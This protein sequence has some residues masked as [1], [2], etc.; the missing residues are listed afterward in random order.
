MPSMP[1]KEHKMLKHRL[2]KA[3]ENIQNIPD[4]PMLESVDLAFNMKF[5]DPDEDQQIDHYEVR[6]A[7]LEFMSS[8][9]SDY[10]KYLKDPSNQ[11]EKITCSNDFFDLVSFRFVK[12]AKKQYQFIYKLTDTNLFSYFIESRCLG[13]SDVDAQIMHFDKLCNSKRSRMNPKYVYPFMEQK[14][15]KAESPNED[16]LEPDLNLNYRVFP[17]FNQ[18]NFIRPRM[19]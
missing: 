3:S 1:F 16:G 9:M 8:I 6:D 15:V 11:P 19:I 7:F 14:S 5:L 18:H 13:K 2:I 10:T 4:I 17:R 12:D